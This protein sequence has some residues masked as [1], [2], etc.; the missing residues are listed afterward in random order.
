MWQSWL[1]YNIREYWAY[2]PYP[3]AFGGEGKSTLCIR[4]YGW[5]LLFGVYYLVQL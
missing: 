1:V 5:I 2:N 3:V 4:W